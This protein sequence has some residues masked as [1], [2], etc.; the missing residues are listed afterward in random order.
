MKNKI[1]TPDLL[2]L[3]HLFF[4]K[5]KQLFL[6][7]PHQKSTRAISPKIIF[8]NSL[9]Q[10]KQSCQESKAS[11]LI[12]NCTEQN[13][14][15]FLQTGLCD[16]IIDFVYQPKKDCNTYYFINNANQSMRWIF[17][18]NSKSPAFLELYNSSGLKATI[19]KRLARG[20][21]RLSW[22]RLLI[23]G[24][25]SIS[26]KT[27][28][29]ISRHFGD[30]A[31]DDY[32]IFTG[33]VGEN[34]K[35][36]VALCKEEVCT[37][38]IKIPLAESAQR[39]V[40]WEYQQLQKI[41]QLPLRQLWVPWVKR[42]GKGV[43]VGNV[44]PIQFEKCGGFHLSHLQALSELYSYSAKRAKLEEVSLQNTV[45]AGMFFFKNGS[46]VDNGLAT[47]LRQE[48]QQCCIDFFDQ[49]DEQVALTVAMGHGDFTPWNIY[50][51]KTQVCVY[52]W[53]MSRDDLPLLFDVFHYC[54]QKGILIEQKK[55]GDIEKEIQ[56]IMAW[57]ETQTLLNQY[58]VDWRRY[59][60]F[61]LLHIV[62]YYLPKYAVQ[63]QLHQQVHWLVK[64]WLEA[65]HSIQRYKRLSSEA[66]KPIV[67]KLPYSSRKTS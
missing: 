28:T 1:Q 8:C 52:D 32:A 64:T 63:P 58:K 37:S 16:G 66:S 27:A 21:H 47:A 60:S 3:Q 41:Q 35:A 15:A 50:R 34:R 12:V 57:P 43:A 25:F 46:P 11:Y 24:C 23:N 20:L 2:I 40:D 62:C 13:L 33:T 31:F 30:L 4:A 38:F 49:L 67:E 55:W 44:K 5:T 9:T 18:W 22:M 39:L 59:L 10:L 53:E 54:F 29:T 56:A 26:S 42:I 14:A 48:L 7:D 36:I 6:F 61:Y 19:F 51:T 17:P 45:L 65:W